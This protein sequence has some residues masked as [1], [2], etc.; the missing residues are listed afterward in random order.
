MAEVQRRSA[1]KTCN[2]HLELDHIDFESR[3]DLAAWRPLHCP[4]LELPTTHLLNVLTFGLPPDDPSA[5]P[6]PTYLGRL[7]AAPLLTTESLAE[8][9][10]G[11]HTLAV[12]TDNVTRSLLFRAGGGVHVG[13]LHSLLQAEAGTPTVLNGTVRYGIYKGKPTKPLPHH[14]ARSFGPVD[15]ESAASVAHCVA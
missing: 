1:A 6:P 7:N 3:F 2:R 11:G 12:S 15:V 8:R 13:L 14:L 4:S 5:P 10:L 9:R